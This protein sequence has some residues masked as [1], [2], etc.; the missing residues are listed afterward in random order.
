MKYREASK[1]K[2]VHLV[3]FQLREELLHVGKLYIK[4]GNNLK[5]LKYPFAFF[6][7]AL[8]IC[9]LLEIWNA[10][11]LSYF[12]HSVFASCLDFE[13][14]STPAI[15]LHVHTILRLL[16]CKYFLSWLTLQAAN[17]LLY[18][19]PRVSITAMINFRGEYPNCFKKIHL[20]IWKQG[21][22]NNLYEFENDVCFENGLV[23][24]GIIVCGFLFRRITNGSYE[25]ESG[26]LMPS[27]YLGNHC[28]SREREPS[29]RLS[30]FVFFLNIISL[31]KEP[32][33]IFLICHLHFW[34]LSNPKITTKQ[35][36]MQTGSGTTFQ[37]DYFFRQKS[38]F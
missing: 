21:V 3:V 24:R 15:F 6:F 19:P 14:R 35:C 26:K 30:T 32:I 33:Y 12:L 7:L 13:Q 37:Q 28:V 9:L 8:N 25:F 2:I 17:N 20:V 23:S 36:G 31:W 22:R 29:G 16:T 10:S 5:P 18:A 34:G 38:F 1:A 4:V 27:K 11:V